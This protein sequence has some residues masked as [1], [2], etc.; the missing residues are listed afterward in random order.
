MLFPVIKIRVKPL[1]GFPAVLLFFSG[2]LALWV[3][4]RFLIRRFN[5]RTAKI[6]VGIF[7]SLNTAMQVICIQLLKVKPSW[8]FGAI[9]SAADDISAGHA[10]R[11]WGY[12]Q[13]YPFNIYSAVIVGTFKYL[14][15]GSPSAP[16]TLNVISVTASI[17]GACL[18]AYRLY[19]Q[20]A[21]VLTAFFCLA[22][23]SFYLYSPIVYT[24]TLSM[25]FAIWTLVAWSYICT[26]EKKLILFCIFMGLLSA[27][28]YMIKQ[29][30]AIGLVAF[31]VD[32][33]FD[34]KKYTIAYETK[35]PL[36]KI[37]TGAV[38]LAAALLSFFLAVS[39]IRVYVGAK[40]FDSRLD[41]SKSL[42]FTH[43]LM[44]GMN[45]LPA[46]GGTSYGYG[47]FSAMDLK[48]SRSYG[49]KAAKMAAETQ[50]MKNRLQVFGIKGYVKF[51]LK[52]TEWTWTDG[53]YF[54]PVKLSRYP[55]KITYLHK[56]VLFS[57]GKSNRLYLVFS[58]FIQT[59]MLTMIFTGCIS[60]LRRAG[61]AYRL[62]SLMCLGL[63]LFLLFWETRSR[64]LVFMI[65]VFVV[66]T[67]QGMLVAFEGLDKAASYLNGRLKRLKNSRSGAP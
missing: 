30:A 18:L 10:I 64:Y 58:Q 53:T 33:V 2:F 16:Y 46:E 28:G 57:K 35:K 21:A 19:G 50:V 12:F 3:L 34:R 42:P 52:K 65:P 22:V 48:Y 38:P 62:M 7:V 5:H 9:M 56:F 36:F 39:A 27:M 6:A 11:N 13:E 26:G 32:F 17:L 24:D 29:I 45:T 15:G 54:A 25:P 31:A 66:M 40:G 8:D 14:A 43:W 63:M 59:V 49:T 47:G 51:L 4:D 37:L 23:T 55:T 41:D 61:R 60:A 44:M 67:I 1:K 20:R